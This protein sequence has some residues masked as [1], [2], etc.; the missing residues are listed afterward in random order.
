MDRALISHD[1]LEHFESFTVHHT[2]RLSADHSPLY[3]SFQGTQK[4]YKSRFIFQRMWVDHP[5][6]KTVVEQAWNMQVIGS[7]GY[8]F[9]R[10]IAHLSSILKSWNW[11]VF[12]NT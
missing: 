8:T 4:K 12:G 5:N 9:A 11:N 2:A 1:F 10:K 6:L 7:P 3:L